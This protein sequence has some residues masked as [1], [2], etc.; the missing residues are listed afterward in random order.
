M[1]G[2]KRDLELTGAGIHA[3]GSGAAINAM[4]DKRDY[5]VEE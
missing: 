3:N 5:D 1:A 2:R 4:D